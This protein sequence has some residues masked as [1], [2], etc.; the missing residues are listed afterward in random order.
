MTH[1]TATRE[2][3][4]SAAVILHHPLDYSS[5]SFSEPRKAKLIAPKVIVHL[6]RTKGCTAPVCG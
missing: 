2:R 4:T 5:T 1:S 6:L 3:L